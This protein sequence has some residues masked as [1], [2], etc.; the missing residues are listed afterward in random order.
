MGSMRKIIAERIAAAITPVYS[1][2]KL[3]DGTITRII[4]SFGSLK[5]SELLKLYELVKIGKEK[6]KK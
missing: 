6:A 2:T 1:N 3:Y 4:E 5:D